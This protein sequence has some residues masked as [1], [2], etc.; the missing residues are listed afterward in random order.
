MS[1]AS[2]MERVPLEI[3]IESGSTCT[4]RSQISRVERFIIFKGTV[5]VE[6]AKF[7]VW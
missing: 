6:L 2:W 7:K 1:I 3:E 5:V 4:S